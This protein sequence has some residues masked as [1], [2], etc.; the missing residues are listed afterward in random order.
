MVVS[1]CSAGYYFKC[2]SDADYCC[3]RNFAVFDLLSA[4]IVD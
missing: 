2:S 3:L 4:D 1:N